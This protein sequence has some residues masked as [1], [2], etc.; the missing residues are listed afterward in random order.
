MEKRKNTFYDRYQKVKYDNITGEE[1][2]VVNIYYN[3]KFIC[4]L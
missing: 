3:L 2:E 1:Q 4:F